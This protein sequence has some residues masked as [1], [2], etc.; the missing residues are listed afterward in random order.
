MVRNDWLAILNDSVIETPSNNFDSMKN[1][2]SNLPTTSFDQSK[3]DATNN[4]YSSDNPT[5]CELF[6]SSQSNQP[7]PR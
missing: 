5:N 2:S 4:Q 1:Q 6:T 7:N 3:K